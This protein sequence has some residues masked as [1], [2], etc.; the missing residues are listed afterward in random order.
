MTQLPR[1]AAVMQRKYRGYVVI[2]LDGRVLGF[3]KDGI[4]A[5]DQAKKKDKDIEKKEFLISRVH[6]KEPIIA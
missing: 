2:S 3:G 6:G 1:I 5:L 4:L